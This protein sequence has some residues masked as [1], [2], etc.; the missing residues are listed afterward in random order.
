M[1]REREQNHPFRIWQKNKFI[2]VNITHGSMHVLS[3]FASVLLFVVMFFHPVFSTA[4]TTLK[5]I[6]DGVAPIKIVQQS[7]IDYLFIEDPAPDLPLEGR[8]PILFVHGWNF[9]GAPAPPGGDAFVA[10]AGF[11]LADNELSR[12]YKPYIVRYWSNALPVTELAGLLRDKMDIMGLNEKPYVLLAHSMGGLISRSLMNEHIFTRGKYAGITCGELARLLI[13]L[14]TPHHGSPMANYTSRNDR[15]DPIRDI[16]MVALLLSIEEFVFSKTP[17][18]KVNRSDLR[19]DNYD[20]L[21]NYSKYPDEKNVWLTNLNS[22]TLFDSKLVCYAGN[23]AGELV[24]PPYDNTD[25]QYKMAAYVQRRIFNFNNDG[26]V[27][28]Q[29]ALFDGHLP[30]KTR[31]FENYDHAQIVRGKTGETIL[32][33]S[34]R[35]DL[36]EVVPPLLVSPSQENIIV[37][38]GELFEIQ[39]ANPSPVELV[40]IYFSANNGLTFTKIA[41]NIDAQIQSYQW[42]VPDTNSVNCIIRVEKAGEEGLFS[43]SEQPFTIYHNKL[44]VKNPVAGNYLVQERENTISWEQSGVASGV[45]ITYHDE[46]NGI[47]KVINE[48]FPAVNGLNTFS[49]MPEMP[50]PASDSVFISFEMLD[51]RHGS[52]TENYIFNSAHF[53]MLDFPKVTFLSPVENPVDF[54]GKE[55]EK[56]DINNNYTIGYETE[57]EIKFVKISLCDSSKNIIEIVRRKN[58]T[59]GIKSTNSISWRVPELYGDKYFLYIEAGLRESEITCSAYTPY[60]FRINKSL[61]LLS[62]LPNDRDISCLPCFSVVPLSGATS[63]YFEICDSISGGKDY[64]KSFSSE[65]GE[66]CFS[67]SVTDELVA[68]STYRLTA[69]AWIDSLKSYPL[70]TFFSTSAQKPQLFSLLS[71]AVDDTLWSERVEFSWERAVGANDYL[72]QLFHEDNLLFSKELARTDTVFVLSMAP[73]GYRDTIFVNVSARNTWGKQIVESWFFNKDRVT[74][75]HLMFENASFGLSCF[76]NPMLNN[77]EITFTL[78]EANCRLKVDLSLFSIEGK[79]ASSLFDGM[80]NGG[81]HAFEINTSQ[82]Q[83]PAGVYFL[84][85]N[86]DGKREV[87]KIAIN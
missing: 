7:E 68:G 51:A 71:P 33:D 62:P 82:L 2:V 64:L 30:K 77:A 54:D 26:I 79:V 23:I 17:Y 24:P 8:I 60:S 32:Q 81:K 66:V 31:Y 40:N 1:T 49:W 29:S 45:K 14:G 73:E 9:N 4:Q 21:M 19:W 61:E 76:P 78:P 67:N 58:H 69:W 11:F 47:S 63:Y 41:S 22:Y 84:L 87:K 72:L 28:R 55:G 18:N 25:K 43:Q 37:K 52:D 80:L 15:L 5:G 16:A 57:G 6:A 44:D 27:P 83:L 36:L 39:W 13:T 3:F 85:L 56:L 35:K 34:L 75:P 74:T 38:H 86:V 20:N 70:Q 12:F 53:M 50:L 10:Y 59:P 46:K 65:D 42:Q 48:N